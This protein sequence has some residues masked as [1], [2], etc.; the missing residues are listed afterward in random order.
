MRH[1]A[2]YI[3]RQDVNSRTEES[4]HGRPVANRAFD[5]IESG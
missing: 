2:T 3:I 4:L 5:A 1:G